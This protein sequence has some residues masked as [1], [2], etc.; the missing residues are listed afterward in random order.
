MLQ[1]EVAHG[2]PIQRQQVGVAGA[3]IAGDG[4]CLAAVRPAPALKI[5]HQL[6]KAAVLI[7]I[8]LPDADLRPQAVMPDPVGVQSLPWSKVDISLVVTGLRRVGIAAQYA[9]IGQQLAHGAGF[10]G[11]EG[12][13]MRAPGIGGDRVLRRCGRCRRL[14]IPVPE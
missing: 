14:P 4:E 2:Q 5:V 12:Q 9:E 3:E 11:G 10:T 6:L 8:A 7:V 13:V 1:Q